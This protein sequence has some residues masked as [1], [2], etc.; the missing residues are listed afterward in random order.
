MEVT[1]KLNINIDVIYIISVHGILAKNKLTETNMHKD[2]ALILSKIHNDT[3]FLE[4]MMKLHDTDTIEYTA[5]MSQFKSQVQREGSN[6]PHCPVCGSTNL[7]NRSFFSFVS[8]EVNRR[9]IKS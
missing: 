9:A 5:K 4:S 3:N 2:D 6:V 8:A 1:Q 7:L